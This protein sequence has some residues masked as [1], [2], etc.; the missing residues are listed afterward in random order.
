MMTEMTIANQ[1]GDQSTD[2]KQQ[3]VAAGQMTKNK[4]TPCFRI[5][6]AAELKETKCYQASKA[7]PADVTKTAAAISANGLRAA[8]RFLRRCWSSFLRGHVFFFFAHPHPRG[9]CGHAPRG[10]GRVLWGSTVM[11]AI[12]TY[13]CCGSLYAEPPC[14]AASSQV[15]VRRSGRLCTL[16]PHTFHEFGFLCWLRP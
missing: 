3:D 9:A 10:R 13:T 6:A 4:N 2:F 12:L 8:K 1:D 15:S 14:Y 7:K 11:E 16:R 5:S